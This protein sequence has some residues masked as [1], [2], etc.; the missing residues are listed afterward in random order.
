MTPA[1]RT[2]S[3]NGDVESDRGP[4]LCNEWVESSFHR[5]WSM[6]HAPFQGLV[7]IF[8]EN[9][10][11]CYYLKQFIFFTTSLERSSFPSYFLTDVS[12]A[13]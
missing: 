7:C 5:L 2:S 9:P 8:R 11:C 10:D 6:G 12:M 3:D 4:G 13:K 1:L